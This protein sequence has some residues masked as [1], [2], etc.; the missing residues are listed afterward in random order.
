MLSLSWA[1][2]WQLLKN[3]ADTLT[4]MGFKEAEITGALKA[5]RLLI[6]QQDWYSDMGRKPVSEI[7]RAWLSTPEI[8]TFIQVNRF[9]DILWY[10]SDAFKE[11]LWWMTTLAFVHCEMK[12]DCSHGESLETLLECYAIMQQLT[13]ADKAARF[14][15]EKLLDLLQEKI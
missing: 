9:E 10:N 2:E 13:Q 14:K 7:A 6:N 1:E 8:Q 15:L 5:L 3:F 4:E 12:S 11:F